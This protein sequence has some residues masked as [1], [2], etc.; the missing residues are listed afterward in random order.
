MVSNLRAIA[1]PR[2]AMTPF[3]GITRFSCPNCKNGPRG[4]GFLRVFETDLSQSKIHTS[5]GNAFPLSCASIASCS[6]SLH[7]LI[8]RSSISPE[9]SPCASKKQKLPSEPLHLQDYLDQTRFSRQT[10]FYHRQ[11]SL[12]QEACTSTSKMV[13]QVNGTKG[14]T[15]L[16]TSESV[17]EG[18][19]DKIADQVYTHSIPHREL[20][21][22][23]C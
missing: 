3:H 16:F 19:P 14:E 23:S 6:S 15:F 11:S 17:G 18:H 22:T 1:A 21:L 7:L 5:S 10:L 4:A 13:H 9:P 2:F 20:C 8:F 12:R